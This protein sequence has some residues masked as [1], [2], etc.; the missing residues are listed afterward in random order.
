[1]ITGR[2]I[3]TVPSEITYLPAIQ[4]FARE[5]AREIGFNGNDQE[6]ILL[7]LEEAVTNVIEHAFESAE[8]S[9]QIIFEPSAGGIEIIVKDKG[10]PYDPR[11]VPEYETPD[12][13]ELVSPKGLGSLIMKKCVDEVSFHNLGKEGK[14]L[15]LIKRLPRKTVLEHGE[16]QEPESLRESSGA[17]TGT[18]SPPRFETRLMRSS[19]ALEV[20]RTFYRTY[21]YSYLSDVMYYPD[22]LAELNANGLITSAIAVTEHG[23]IAGHLAITR[24]APD[25]MIAETGKGAV[26]PNFRG[27]DI[28]TEMQKFLNDEAKARGL[29]ALYGRSVTVHP[30]TQKMTEKT[31]YKDCAVVLGFAPADMAFKGM[32]NQLSQRESLVYCFQPVVELPVSSVYLPPH[33]EPILRKIFSNLGLTKSFSTSRGATPTADLSVMTIKAYFEI[34]SAEI[35]VHHYGKD[36]TR[37]LRN[38]LK[39]LCA[40]KVEHIT[41]FLNLGDPVTSHV[42]EEIEGLG[43]FMAGIIPCLHFEDTLILQY[44][45]NVIIDYSRIRLHSPM[46][47]EIVAYIEEH[48]KKGDEALLTA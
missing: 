34:N 35:V 14:E 5:F 26:K 48:K 39:D 42:C 20:S 45:N 12:S 10:L 3:L 46:A 41:L 4:A 43:F 33:H 21:G 38:H 47:K 2:S 24:D 30:A 29:K 18:S 27:F 31:G 36:C 28:F 16:N 9:F 6:M 44:L 19:E 40:R 8:Q 11:L 7:A 17:K 22:R 23:E 37:V 32:E 1:M 25:D 15:H 13:I